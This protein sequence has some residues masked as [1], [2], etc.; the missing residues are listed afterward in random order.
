MDILVHMKA[1]HKQWLDENGMSHLTEGPPFEYFGYDDVSRDWT[2]FPVPETYVV[3][4]W[5]ENDECHY[6]ESLDVFLNE[7]NKRA[8]S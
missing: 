7:Y 4:E 5:D 8:E 6:N 1:H 2:G 3:V